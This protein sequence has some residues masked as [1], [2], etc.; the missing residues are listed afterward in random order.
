MIFLRCTSSLCSNS[1]RNSSYCSASCSNW[2]CFSSSEMVCS[3]HLV[4]SILS[5]WAASIPPAISTLRTRANKPA[6]KISNSSE[7]SFLACFN[8]IS[9]I[10]NARLSF[11]TPSRVKTWTSITVPLTLF[12]TRN[13]ESFTSD[14]FSPKIARNNFSSGVNCVSPLGVTLPTKMSPPFT[15]APTYTIPD[16]SNLLNADSP[17]FGI[18]AVISSEPNLVSRATQDN[19]WMWIVVKRSCCTTRSETNIESSK[20]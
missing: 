14:A 7:R 3:N 11:S 6:S 13:E 8:C 2:F 15:S 12:G 4:R 10:S 5:N 19:S 18:S 17:T 16:S 1:L 20:L 9:S